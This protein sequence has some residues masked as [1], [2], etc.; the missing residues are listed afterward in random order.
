ML[1]DGE[2]RGSWVGLFRRKVQGRKAG[3]KVMSVSRGLSCWPN[4]FLVGEA[5]YI[6]SF[7]GFYLMIQLIE[8]Q[9]YGV[10][11]TPSGLQT[12]FYFILV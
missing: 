3:F 2:G 1:L 8:L 7:W 10:R 4:P 11:T 6:I 9:F 5:M 12:P